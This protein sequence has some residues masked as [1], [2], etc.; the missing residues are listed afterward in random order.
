[1][2]PQSPLKFF[3][4]ACLV[5]AW[6]GIK[7]HAAGF[8]LLVRPSPEPVVVNQELTFTMDVTNRMG[9]TVTN[10]VVTNVYP[11]SAQLSSVSNFFGGAFTNAGLM[12]LV[13]DVLTNNQPA[14]VEFSVV[15]TVLG[16]LTNNVSLSSFPL[17]NAAIVTTNVIVRVVSGIGDLAAGISGP[18]PGVLVNDWITYRVAATNFGP[19]SVPGVVLTNHLPTDFKLL[20]VNPSNS[21]VSFTNGA[22]RFSLGTLAAGAFASFQVRVQ[23]TNAGPASLRAQVAAA[24]AFDTNAANNLVTNTFDVGSFLTGQLSATLTSTQQYNPQTGLMEQLLSL[25]NTGETAVAS[26]RVIVQGLTN[27]LFNAVGTN[28][29]LPFVV[30]ATNLA[31][32][33]S[34][35]ML[36]EYFVTNRMAVSNPTLL[37]L[38]TPAFAPDIPTGTPVHISRLVML[39]S[40]RVLIEFPSETNR[41]YS[42][43]YCGDATFSNKTLVALPPVVAP[44]NRVQWIDYGPPKTV[45][46]PAVTPSRFYKVIQLP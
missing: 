46:H 16:N 4:I 27:R 42:V 36:L 23:P 43:L 44:A 40:G 17:T 21:A 3:L 30:Y 34:V 25:S 24:G 8:E 6:G 5:F 35:E 45:S 14:H 41:Y 33:A 1:M 29:G 28:N 32:G 2:K 26:A 9:F 31:G 20:S 22:L 39:P 12:L 13:I 15:P 18:S 7:L 38:E 19:D 37:A 11:S 10:I